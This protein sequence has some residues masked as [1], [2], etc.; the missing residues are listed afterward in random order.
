MC[1]SQTPPFHNQRDIISQH[2]SVHY[3]RDTRVYMCIINKALLVTYSTRHVNSTRPTPGGRL[4]IQGLNTSTILDGKCYI[5]DLIGLIS[6]AVP[7]AYK[8][9][10]KSR[11]K[12]HSISYHSKVCTS[13]IL[14]GLR[15]PVLYVEKMSH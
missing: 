8:S 3:Q 15:Q 7:A 14:L 5:L 10:T 6:Q 1:A 9:R 2:K 11:L 12:T 13:Q 4:A